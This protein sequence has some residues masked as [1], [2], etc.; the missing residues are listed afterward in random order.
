MD[1]LITQRN[2]LIE[3]DRLVEPQQGCM[4]LEVMLHQGSDDNAVENWL[5]EGHF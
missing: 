4:T 3:A 2:T 1:G 5:L